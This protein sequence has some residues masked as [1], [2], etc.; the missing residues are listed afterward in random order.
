MK[1]GS[2][3]RVQYSTTF[4]ATSGVP[5]NGKPGLC[6]DAPPSGFPLAATHHDSTPGSWTT[7]AARVAEP[8]HVCRMTSHMVLRSSST[9]NTDEMT[10]GRHQNGVQV[11]HIESRQP[12]SVFGLYVHGPSPG[13]DAVASQV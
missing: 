11:D 1:T 6:A 3:N 4:S 10:C 5:D 9:C 7:M 13:P 2:K 8:P 12:G